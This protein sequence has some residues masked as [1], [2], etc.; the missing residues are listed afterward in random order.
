MRI[1]LNQYHTAINYL[2]LHLDHLKLR[3]AGFINKM[4][5]I[6]T[7]WNPSFLAK[8][9]C[10][11][12]PTIEDVDDH[13]F[14]Y[15][16]ENRKLI[17]VDEQQVSWDKNS[18]ETV[19]TSI[20]YLSSSDATSQCK[21]FTDSEGMDS[22]QTK[23]NSIKSQ[24]YEDDSKTSISSNSQEESIEE[25]EEEYKEDDEES[26]TSVSKNSQV[27][28]VEQKNLEEDLESKISDTNEE[29]EIEDDKVN[30]DEEEIAVENG[31]D[32]SEDEESSEDSR[33]E[34]KALIG[35]MKDLSYDDEEDIENESTFDDSIDSIESEI[36]PPSLKAGLRL[37]EQALARYERL[38]ALANHL[39]SSKVRTSNKATSET[40]RYVKLYE[41]GLQRQSQKVSKRLIDLSVERKQKQKSHSPKSST[42][43]PLGENK[44]CI[45]LYNLSLQ[46]QKEGRKRRTDIKVAS[47]KAKEIYQHPQKISPKE[48]D[49]LYYEG[50]K[51]LLELDYRRIEA[52]HYLQT[53]HKPFLFREELKE[54]VH[55]T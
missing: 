18:P 16:E 36:K 50:V 27:D 46:Q 40:P 3:L 51:Q 11:M 45:R 20:M 33:K 13:F 43:K 41:L 31:L 37:Y 4:P 15:D 22:F 21:S 32:D 2:L 47:E 6:T 44:R 14:V 26:E 5:D 23:S 19:D 38:E 8:F 34:I 48:G 28:T 10:A 29:L 9:S 35:D 7:Q 49:R 53:Q 1:V 52:A 25:E 39:D 24:E 30:A 54:K 12:D 17:H 42:K 55:S